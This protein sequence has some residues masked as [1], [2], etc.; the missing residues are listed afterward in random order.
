MARSDPRQAPALAAS[1]NSPNSN[2]QFSQ[3]LSTSGSS[4]MSTTTAKSNH[5]SALRSSVVRLQEEV[6]VFLTQKMA[7]DLAATSS[8]DGKA[9]DAS[10]SID[11]EEENYGE[12]MVDGEV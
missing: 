4:D 5:L 2:K 7:E 3:S 10:I 12:E 9:A 1:Y 8:G 11:D 6:N